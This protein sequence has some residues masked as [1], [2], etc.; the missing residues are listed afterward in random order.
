M[1]APEEEAEVSRKWIAFGIVGAA[2]VAGWIVSAAPPERE[3]RDTPG[4]SGSVVEFG[5]TGDG[6]TDDAVAIE[7]AI[8]SGVGHV[9]FP[10]G[11]YRITRPIVIDLDTTG[12]VSLG[13]DGVARI[14]MAGAGPAFRFVGTHGGTADPHTVKDNVWQRQRMPAVDGVEIIGDHPE[15]CGIE[16]KGTMQLTLTGLTVRN[17]LHAV[18]LVE[19]NRNV[20]L[21]ECHL[22]DN[23]GVGVFLD[24]V[25]LHQINIGN[26]HISYNQGGGVVARGSELR[27]LQIGACDIEGN[28][29]GPDSEP[30]A[31]VLLESSGSSIA[32]VAI[33]GC[34]LQHTHEGS[35]SANIR[36]DAKSAKRANT[37]ELRYGNIT[38]ADNVLSD[39]QVNVE[40]RNAR[41]VTITGNTFWQAYQHNLVV[42]GSANV[43]LAHNVFDRNP[44]YHF[45]NAEQ[46]GLDVIFADSSDCTITGNHI[47]GTGDV[48]AAMVLRNCRRMNVTGCTILDY[49]HAGLLLDNVTDSRVS[50]CLIR[51]DRPQSSSQSLRVKGGRGNMIVDNLLGTTPEID[52]GSAAA[53]DNV[54]P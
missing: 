45:G 53:M 33:V 20:I 34:T 29:G 10:K 8:L 40:V 48:P 7:R 28:M 23:R 31:N 50:D 4:D 41:A 2:I 24:G 52:K 44:R 16:A 19:R 12:F 49:A 54:Q 26:C 30:T 35:S 47:H 13:G 9:R 15:A 25:N 21:S 32:E 46:A 42:E 5:A 18:H 51:D 39:V 38:I 36:I 27:N 43:V 3:A 1:T 14:V 22:Y 37:D 6:I 17:V 11:V